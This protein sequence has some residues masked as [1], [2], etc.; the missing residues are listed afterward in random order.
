[1]FVNIEINSFECIYSTYW[2]FH[3]SRVG[4][5]F[6][7]SINFFSK[8]PTSLILHLYL[9]Q[10][11]QVA[12]TMVIQSMTSTVSTT[13]MSVTMVPWATNS[14]PSISAMVVPS[15][16]GISKTVYDSDCHDTHGSTANA[17]TGTVH[18]NST[19]HV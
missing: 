9:F 14:K 8:F 3:F 17:V 12:P 10:V 19:P 4:F 13:Q 7:G 15:I 5:T 16:S 2:V 6:F 18:L 1:M 11:R